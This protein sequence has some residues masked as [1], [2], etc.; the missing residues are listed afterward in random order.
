LVFVIL[1]VS[2]DFWHSRNNE[3][4]V[5][6]GLHLVDVV[7]V[8]SFVHD[9]VQRVQEVDD[10]QGVARLGHQ[11][12]VDDRTRFKMFC[13]NR[14][15]PTAKVRLVLMWFNLAEDTWISSQVDLIIIVSIFQGYS[16]QLD[17]A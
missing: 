12:K 9:V 8:H 16:K 7:V 14:F 15:F 10:L 5:R 6:D 1:L 3:I 11:A 2:V 13:Q 4:G 17:V